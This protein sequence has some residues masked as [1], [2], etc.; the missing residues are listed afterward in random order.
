MS[1]ITDLGK[2]FAEL[3]AKKKELE[4]QV[5]AINVDL[6][7][8]EVEDIPK[9]MEDN[10]LTKFTIDGIGT[11]SLQGVTYVSVLKDNRPELY[12]WLREQGHEDL[13]VDWVFPKTLEAFTKEQLQKQATEGGNELPEI[14]KVTHIP[15]ARLRRST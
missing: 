14:I 8:L 3:K 5:K 1:T 7:K 9:L 12:D 15:T 10:D 13:I 6:K 11:I 2:Q 4:D